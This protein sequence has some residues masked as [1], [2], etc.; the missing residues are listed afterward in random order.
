M[1]KVSKIFDKKEDLETKIL[2][3]RALNG[4]KKRKVV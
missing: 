3:N 2:K 4:F 1:A